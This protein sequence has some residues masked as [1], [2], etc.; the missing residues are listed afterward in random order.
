MADRH[1]L[2]TWEPVRIGGRRLGP[3]RVGGGWYAAVPLSVLAVQQLLPVIGKISKAMPST[4]EGIAGLIARFPTAAIAPMVPL[5]VEPRVK[6]GHLDRIT[7]EQAVEVFLASQR[8]NDW[9]YIF[10]AM[11]PKPGEKGVS[12]TVIAVNLGDRFKMDPR[13]WLLKPMQEFLATAEA[14]TGETEP[15]AAPLDKDDRDLF[16]SVGFRVN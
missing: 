6:R 14:L 12:I 16:A 1:F 11:T 7:P 2:R 4:D 9:P 5:L 13:D 3:L 15:E 8:V 10:D